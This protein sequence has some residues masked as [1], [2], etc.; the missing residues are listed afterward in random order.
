MNYRIF[1]VFYTS[2]TIL[3]DTFYFPDFLG[4][5]CFVIWGNFI[6][7]TFSYGKNIFILFV[8][9]HEFRLF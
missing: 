4:V 6:F 3:Y 9:M 7:R 8:I 1:L 2:E 5:M